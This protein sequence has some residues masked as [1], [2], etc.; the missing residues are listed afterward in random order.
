MDGPEP[1]PS[2]TRNT[3]RS[4]SSLY[5][6]ASSSR[7]AP[8]IWWDYISCLVTRNICCFFLFFFL[9]PHIQICANVV[10]ISGRTFLIT[11]PRYLFSSVAVGCFPSHQQLQLCTVQTWRWKLIHHLLPPNPNSPHPLRCEP[12]F[13]VV[14][15][16]T[17]RR[18]PGE[19]MAREENVKFHLRGLASFTFLALGG[20][21]NMRMKRT[22]EIKRWGVSFACVCILMSFYISNV[23]SCVILFFFIFM[24]VCHHGPLTCSYSAHF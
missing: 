19:Q 15:I 24:C 20:E 16:G 10:A 6:R 23:A 1:D 7:V 11:A 8:R 12:L 14:L 3:R 2:Q 5:Q 21:K 9:P 17:R 4:Q 18:I 13:A 22:E